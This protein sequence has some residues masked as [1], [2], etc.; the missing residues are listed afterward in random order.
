MGVAAQGGMSH[1]FPTIVPAAFRAGRSRYGSRVAIPPEA[2]WLWNGDLQFDILKRQIAAIRRH[3]YSSVVV[4]PWA[5]LE[6]PLGAARH[7]DAIQAACRA[8]EEHD[9]SLWLADDVNWP[10]GTAAGTLLTAHP[11]A[12]QQALI[13]NSRW[14]GQA[15]S[16][17][18][19]W[20]GEGEQLVVAAAVED[21]GSRLDL[22]GMLEE[23]GTPVREPR[24]SHFGQHQREWEAELWEAE[25]R[26]PPGG[27][28]LLV[29]TAV[30]TKPLLPSTCGLAWAHRTLGTLDV[31]SAASVSL[32]LDLAVR[33][34]VE[35]AMPWLGRS[36][37]GLVTAPAGALTAHPIAAPEGWRADVFPWFAELPSR[38]AER[39]GT[40]FALEL[41]ERIA[42]LHGASSLVDDPT[43]P[44]TALAAEQAAE[45]YTG[46]YRTWC[47]ARGV[48]LLIAEPH[49][50]P[51][52]PYTL[53]ADRKRSV[54]PSALVGVEASP[55]NEDRLPGKHLRRLGP[56]L[57]ISGAMDTTAAPWTP[58]V[59]L[60][61]VWAWEP[62]SAN[63]H[64]LSEWAVRRAGPHAK[65]D[66]RVTGHFEAECIPN[67][68]AIAFE[69]GVLRELA[70]NG[71]RVPLE[72]PVLPA[73]IE[74]ADACLAALPLP[75]VRAGRNEIEAVITVP[76]AE[77]I[78]F[79][80][81]PV[82]GPFFVIGSFALADRGSSTAI[83]RPPGE[84]PE[85]DWSALGYPRYTGSATYRQ[86]FVLRSLPD[87]VAT[88]LVVEARG[89]VA[90]TL[91]DASLGSSDHSPC[92]FDVAEKLR[93][94]VNELAIV[95]F[96]RLAA[97]IAGREPSGLFGARLEFRP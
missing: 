27:W 13:C 45:S 85:G 62:H 43:G 3:G 89:R 52:I 97:R 48:Q 55:P 50:L 7:L 30:R 96:N 8:A 2:R 17:R 5:G 87:R 76:H 84:M 1:E 28:F 22:A 59:E 60:Q 77:R 68:M 9:L 20:R 4:W 42:A 35:T 32:F 40:P 49:A 16:R 92:I 94:G 70:V 66:L 91:N 18:V 6:V 79:H 46:T 69:R 26:L 47:D 24:V 57:L 65:D 56:L 86:S 80:S 34:L 95:V 10:S 33:P 36:F 72:A 39:T 29:A 73:P 25:L 75:N 61:K 19:K 74:H 58:L 78:A 64:P 93:P 90:V 31:L 11:E 83:V 41:P 37:A 53:K 88:R 82:L 15:E 44:I 23:R 12:A 63:V 14:L 71:R 51:A 81:V 38:L 67:D 21:A 54:L